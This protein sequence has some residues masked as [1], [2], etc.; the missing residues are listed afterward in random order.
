M[1]LLLNGT[2]N[3]FQRTLKRP[4]PPLPQ[5]L[6]STLTFRNP[7]PMRWQTN[8][9]GRKTFPQ[10]LHWSG[11]RTQKLIRDILVFMGGTHWP[12]SLWGQ[13]LLFWKG[14]GDHGLLE[15]WKK[16]TTSICCP[17]GQEEESWELQAV[18]PPLDYWESVEA[19]IPGNSCQD[20]ILSM[21]DRK[22][23][24]SSL[25]IMD[26]WW[27]NHAWPI[28]LPPVMGWLA[29]RTKSGYCLV[30]YYLYLVRF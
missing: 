22:V 21:E 13:C 28:L 26:L 29:W 16:T 3:L 6:L 4:K 23:T 17:G 19:T 5:F 9:R 8:S 11:K 12:M 27:G 18:Q 14:H 15:N 10:C 24:G 30:L 25:V 20:S 1:G 7:K 2:G